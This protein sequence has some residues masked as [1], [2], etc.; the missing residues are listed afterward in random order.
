MVALLVLEMFGEKGCGVLIF[1]FL[2][3]MVIL[4]FHQVFFNMAR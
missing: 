2:Q 1:V 3:G 4:L